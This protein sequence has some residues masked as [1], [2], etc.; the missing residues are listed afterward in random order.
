MSEFDL[1]NPGSVN[2]G[3]PNA[4]IGS[5]VGQAS[6]DDIEKAYKELESRFGSQGQEL[7]EYRE[8]FKNLGPLLEKL[9]EMP[10]LV[11][12]LEEGKVDKSLAIAIAQG[13]VTIKQAEAITDQAKEEVKSTLGKKFGKTDQEDVAKLVST[14]VDKIRN[15]LA[16]KEDLK[17]YE[18][19]TTN[20]IASTPDFQEYADAIDQWLGKHDDVTDIEI[21]YYAVKGQL[22]EKAAR[23]AREKDANEVAK[24]VA[25]NAS[26]GAP[27]ATYSESGISLADQL[28]AGR[29]NPNSFFP[30]A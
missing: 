30:G 1:N 20:F 17:S 4:P 28:I 16:E 18:A 2:A 27:R 26:G 11:K 13:N 8:L 6:K 9:D 14:E 22:S 3:S 29:P 5:S 24:N 7:G 12:A 19:Y 15:E 10:E 23:E 25:L 21:A